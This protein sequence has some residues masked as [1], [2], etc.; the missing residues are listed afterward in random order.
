MLPLT[1][2][3]DGPVGEPHPGAI[4]E[5]SQGI[6]RT[7]VEAAFSWPPAG[8]RNARAGRRPGPLLTCSMWVLTE[9]NE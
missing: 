6:H 4:H 2:L 8:A 1:V 9:C 7:Q 5:L 3:G